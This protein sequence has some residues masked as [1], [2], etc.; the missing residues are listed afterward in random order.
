MRIERFTMIVINFL[1]YSN[2]T[3][4]GM[5][6]RP[7]GKIREIARIILNNSLKYIAGSRKKSNNPNP[8]P[9]A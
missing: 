2:S 5:T 6:A 3:E 1:S 7:T 8:N 4:K 9:K